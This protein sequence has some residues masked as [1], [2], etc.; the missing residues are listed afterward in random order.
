MK[1]ISRYAFGAVLVAILGAAAAVA[2]ASPN[3]PKPLAHQLGRNKLFDRFDLNRDGKVTQEEINKVLS[4]RFAAA[5]GGSSTISELQ[6]ANMRLDDVRKGSEK[7]FRKI[8]WNNDGKIGRE[9]FLNAEH[10]RFNRMDKRATGEVS[11]APRAHAA[12]ADE[13]DGAGASPP[14]GHSGIR[15]A[16]G[17]GFC[18]MYDANKDGKVTRAEFD[19]AAIA[20]FNKYA[21]NG[22]IT[23][24]GFYQMGAAKIQDMQIRRFARLDTNHDGKLTLAE[25]KATEQNMFA[26]LDAN[27]DGFITKDE[28]MAAMHRRFGGRMHGDQGGWH[29]GDWK[30]GK[31]GK[32]GDQ[33][34]G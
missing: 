18:A 19:T 12:K 28:A 24:D 14:R 1:R 17:M 8:D 27:H 33:S 3:E 30:N 11:C 23:R 22:G 26:R 25:F 21:K 5:S 31:G 15:H 4:Q 16:R 9:E 34:P 13:A 29:H 10:I 6:F 32:P 20:Q 2:L 7:L